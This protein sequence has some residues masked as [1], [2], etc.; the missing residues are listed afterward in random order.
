LLGEVHRGLANPFGVVSALAGGI[1][2][3]AFLV[4]IRRWSV[5]FRLDGLV[6]SFATS[7]AAALVI[8]GYVLATDPRGLLPAEPRPEALLG[9]AWLA[10]VTTGAQLLTVLAMRLIPAARAAAFLLLNP[11]SAAILA[12]AL[13]SERASPVQAIGGALVL[14]GI[15]IATLPAATAR[16]AATRTA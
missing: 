11:L 9:L 4:L 14:A 6:I 13:L 8:G 5:R 12:A 3:A 16:R 15:A 2:F 1:S 10:A 7:A